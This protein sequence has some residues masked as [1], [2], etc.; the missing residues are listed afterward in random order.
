MKPMRTQRT[1]AAERPCLRF[2]TAIPALILA[3]RSR[4]L[5][6]RAWVGLAVAIVTLAAPVMSVA[7]YGL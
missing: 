1:P 4:P 3:A 2:F 5:T 6:A 7:R